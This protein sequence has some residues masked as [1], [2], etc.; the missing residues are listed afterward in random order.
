MQTPD[1][2]KGSPP[3]SPANAADPTQFS[4][5]KIA[6]SPLTSSNY[7]MRVPPLV[8]KPCSRWSIFSHTFF[9]FIWS[10]DRPIYHIIEGFEARFGSKR[11]V[12]RWMFEDLPIYIQDGPKMAPLWPQV[13]PKMAPS[14]VKPTATTTATPTN[15]NQQ[16]KRTPTNDNQQPTINNNQQQPTI[17]NTNQ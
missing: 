6:S 13:G 1:I 14:C 15:N 3:L 4:S 11:C 10:R 17:T 7:W 9:H 2:I 8:N 5:P 16:R 12:N